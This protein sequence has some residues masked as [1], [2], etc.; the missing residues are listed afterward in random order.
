MALVP[1][2]CGVL[3][4]QDPGGMGHRGPSGRG[5]QRLE[6]PRWSCDGGP[7][8]P[9]SIPASPPTRSPRGPLGSVGPAERRLPSQDRVRVPP[10]VRLSLPAPLQWARRAPGHPGRLGLPGPLPPMAF[11]GLGGLPCQH[12]QPR[13]CC[14]PQP[15]SLPS[16]PVHA[17]P[18]RAGGFGSVLCAPRGT[19]GVCGPAPSH[20]A[21]RASAVTRPRF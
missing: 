20:Q 19:L 10:P 15:P 4:I 13:P 5:R 3:W 17:S 21:G 18:P 11:S 8:K 1:F 6:A 7:S 2:S 16:G 14:T 9:T 12:L